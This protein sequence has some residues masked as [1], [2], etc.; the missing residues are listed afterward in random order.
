MTI[1][2][3]LKILCFCS[4]T[5]TISAQSVD[6]TKTLND[7]SSISLQ[8][9][10]HFYEALAQRLIENWDRANRE[11]DA[12]LR[13]RNDIP[14]L[15]LE[16][17]K[18]YKSLKDFATAEENLN[19]AL[20]LMP[21]NEILL[22]ELQLVLFMQS[23]YNEQIFALKEL[24]EIDE[25]YK[26]D[27]SAA[28]TYTKQYG[29][30]LE[31]LNDYKQN[32]NFD[33]RIE[34]LRTRIYNLS[35]DKN[36]QIVDIERK[37]QKDK[38]NS[39]LYVRLFELYQGTNNKEEAL[40]V[41]ERFKENVPRAP[42]LEY[43]AF[44]KSLDEG[45][46]LAATESMTKLT[47]NSFIDDRVKKI[48]LSKFRTYGKQ[49]PNYDKEIKKL[50]EEAPS[51][52]EN[53]KFFME[54]T[55]FQLQ[56]G[57]TESLLDVYQKNLEV[58]PNNFSLIRD[59]LLLQLYYNESEKAKELIDISLKKYPSQP[60][61]YLIN[62]TLL[63]KDEKYT[64]AISSYQEGIDYIID[65]PEMER[66]FF[67]KLAEVYTLNGQPEKAKKYQTKGDKISIN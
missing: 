19:A 51:V 24:V 41:Y 67:L 17:A 56:E 10:D 3:R 63:T 20:E 1:I 23:K 13:I 5:I 57:S 60:I 8:F 27:L 58:D 4:L 22:Q 33:S 66:A 42:M 53:Q 38:N 12:C 59:T 30:S 32:Y 62:G 15:Y 50:P 52:T 11:L 44:I 36:L 21:K 35:K 28:Y 49:N 64:K 2:Q 39:N 40:K 26:Y 7:I 31:T 43:V 9:E 29:E 46:T 25:R 54:L 16:K 18:N 45:N 14:I 34:H 55:S 61:L 6:S 65:S 47:S 48:V 37:I